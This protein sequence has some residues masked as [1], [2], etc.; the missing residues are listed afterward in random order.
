MVLGMSSDP[1]KLF[2]FYIRRIYRAYVY[3]KIVQFL[4]AGYSFTV[5]TSSVNL[6]N[7]N[8]KYFLGSLDIS[9]ETSNNFSI[10]LT[11]DFSRNSGNI[12]DCRALSQFETVTSSRKKAIVILWYAQ[13]CRIGPLQ[14]HNNLQN[15]LAIPNKHGIFSFKNRVVAVRS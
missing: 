12:S 4:T 6:S 11:E 5:Y 10:G 8:R 14:I 1:K 7:V 15:S 13:A 2:W 9:K 3:R